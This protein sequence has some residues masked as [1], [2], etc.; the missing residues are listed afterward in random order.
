MTKPAE[1]KKV[2]VAKRIGTAGALILGLSLYALFSDDPATIYP[3]LADRNI[4][5]L[6]LL[7]SVCFI[8]TE[9]LI[10]IPYYRSLRESKKE[11]GLS[12]EDN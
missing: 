6:M 8:G 1:P 5:I 4:V 10:K 12:P 3:S 2:R 9:Q 11:D 7:V